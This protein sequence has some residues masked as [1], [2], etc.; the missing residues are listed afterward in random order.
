MKMQSLFHPVWL[1]PKGD[2]VCFHGS[3]VNRIDSHLFLMVKRYGEKR[4][5][6]LHHA[7]MHQPIIPPER[8]IFL[9]PPRGIALIQAHRV[10][11]GK[12]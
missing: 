2:H 5:F 1:C 12:K 7:D 8:R 6:F 4:S 10:R 9:V 3:G 11:Q